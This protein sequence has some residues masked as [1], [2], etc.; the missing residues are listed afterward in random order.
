MYVK[1]F[2]E[3]CRIFKGDENLTQIAYPRGKGGNLMDFKKLLSEMTLPEKLAQMTQIR[4]ANYIS[5]GNTKL[6]GRSYVFDINEE[7]AWNI[8]S[9]LSL[10]GAK[11]VK[12]LQDEY[13]NKSKNK[14]PLMFMQDVIH[15]FRTIFPSPLAMACSWQPDLL[16]EAAAISAKEAA[17]AGLHVTFSPMADLVR[18]PRW[19]RVIEATGEDP[20][21]NSLYARAFVKGYQGD[22]IKDKYRLASCVKHLAAY[23]AS[24]AGR[25]YNTTDISKYSLEEFYLPAYQAAVE[26]GCKMVM[27]AFN[28]LNG[29]P[30]TGNKEIIQNIL[31]DKW[32]FDGIVISDC[33]SVF[34]LILHGFAEDVAEA[35][36]KAI[37]AGVDIEMVSNTYFNNGLKKIEENKITME[38]IDEM[39]MRILKLKEELGLF[40]NPYKD[41]DEEEEKQ[42]LLC[43]EHR[44]AARRITASSMVLLKNQ[45]NILPI[46]KAQKNVALIGP[47]AESKEL[48]DLWKCEGRVEE[49]VSLAEGLKNR[50]DLKI[51]EGCGIH[52]GTEEKMEEALKLAE[53]SDLIILA[54]GEHPLMSSEA[55]SRAYITLPEVQRE[56]AKKVF[57]LGKPVVVVL[58]NGRPLEL[59][60]IAERADAILECWFPG[61][62]GGNAMADILLGDEYPSGRLTMSF[63]VTVGQIPVY[64]NALPTGRPQKAPENPERFVSR[65]T[66]IPN[67]PL[68]P[69]GYG[70]TYTEFNYSEMQLSSQRL[71]PGTSI[72]AKIKIKNIGDKFG[73]ETVQ[74]YI[75]DLAG[76]MSRPV[77][78]LKGFRKVTLQP[79]EETEVE[80]E[81]T[82]QML[83]FNTLENGFVS[84]AGKFKAFIGKNARDLQAVDFE[85][86]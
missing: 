73:T 20:Y 15:G 4:G 9:I 57:E 65:Y 41:A 6:M 45:G 79:G 83:R 29:V 80:F 25:D 24:E 62:E 85:L 39:V 49:V 21:L 5:E 14:I 63:P 28:S 67:A 12:W 50:L 2:N 70:L 34:E 35:C 82:E 32:G 8:G 26:Q 69:F 71:T 38:Q 77:L 7:L 66:D 43:E 76:S 86:K 13:L 19:G 55:G 64:Y 30:C 48:L 27:T 33:T 68:Y 81:I 37:N 3:F 16:E 75:R 36:E 47:Y 74:L 78:E 54:L 53:N 31:R 11:N 44:A 42:I 61:T 56:L 52:E 59:A 23:G 1:E 84:E 51:S 10:S 58:I 46:S 22:D 72:T 60:E 40:E 18:D 17:V